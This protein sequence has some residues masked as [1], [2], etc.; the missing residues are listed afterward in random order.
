MENENDSLV[1]N[2]EIENDNS[3]NIG[4]SEE[5]SEDNSKKEEPEYSDRERKLFARAK[6]NED[7]AK[8]LREQGFERKNGQWIK[9]EKQTQEN[10]KKSQS[11]E[12]DYGQKAFLRAEGIKTKEEV[13]LVKAFMENTGKSLEEVVENKYFLNELKEQ[14]ELKATE[15]ATPSSSGRSASFPKDKDFWLAKYS[16]G[17]PIMEVP[18]EFRSE[19]LNAKIAQDERKDKFTDKPFIGNF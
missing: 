7:A 15:L 14:R 4:Q 5:K 17:T 3:E 2:E 11:G 16:S 12:L 6:N 9:P 10:P 8:L 1:L 19:V 18:Q 13:D